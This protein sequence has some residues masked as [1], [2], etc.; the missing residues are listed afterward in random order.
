MLGKRYMLFTRVVH[1]FFISLLMKGCHICGIG[2]QSFTANT[3]FYN[4]WLWYSIHS[5]SLSLILLYFLYF[6]PLTSFQQFTQCSF[7]NYFIHRSVPWKR[8]EVSDC[9]TWSYSNVGG[10]R[11][12]FLTHYFVLHPFCEGVYL[13][14]TMKAER[15]QTM[16][17]VF[18]PLP[19]LFFRSTVSFAQRAKNGVGCMWRRGRQENDRDFPCVQKTVWELVVLGSN[20]KL[21]KIQILLWVE[22]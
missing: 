21:F 9:V 18:F 20:E 8:K 11:V 1:G 19:C 16:Y 6:R 10:G 2:N 17:Y 4:G 14:R 15:T 5:L 3:R 13:N 12:P 7:Y 22:R